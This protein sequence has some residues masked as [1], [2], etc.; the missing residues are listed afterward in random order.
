MKLKSL[1][2]SSSS[3]LSKQNHESSSKKSIKKIK[4]EPHQFFACIE[5]PPSKTGNPYAEEIQ[6]LQLKVKSWKS[7]Q[8]FSLNEDKRSQE[9]KTLDDIG[10]AL[11][12]KYAW[13]IP[14]E[15]ALKIIKHFSP[16]VEVGSGKGYWAAMLRKLGNY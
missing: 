5:F 2:K 3:S 11:V 13:A 7:H 9:W 10:L 12:E 8:F 6:E 16:I 14:D 15:R 1:Y 4:E